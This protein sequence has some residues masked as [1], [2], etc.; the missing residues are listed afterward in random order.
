[1]LAEW[2]RWCRQLTS[3]LVIDDYIGD[4]LADKIDKALSEVGDAGRWIHYGWSDSCIWDKLADQIDEALSEVG[5]AGGWIHYWWLI[6]AFE[7][8]WLIKLMTH[9]LCAAA[10]CFPCFVFCSVCSIAVF[11]K[12]TLWSFLDLSGQTVTIPK[13]YGHGALWKWLLNPWLDTV[14]L[15]SSRVCVN[16]H[17]TSQLECGPCSHSLFLCVS[18]W[19]DVGHFWTLPLSIVFKYFCVSCF[20]LFFHSLVHSQRIL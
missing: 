7:I 5:D 14:W 15:D 18:P 6:A 20:P 11:M 19:T 17:D 8:V 13:L 16:C 10:F 4:K 1:M 12:L 3:L 9:W 2:S